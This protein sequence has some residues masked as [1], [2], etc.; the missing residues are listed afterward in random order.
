MYQYGCPRHGYADWVIET[1]HHSVAKFATKHAYITSPHLCGTRQG[2]SFTY[3]SSNVVASF[4]SQAFFPYLNLDHQPLVQGYAYAFHSRDK[5]CLAK[6]LILIIQLYCDDDTQYTAALLLHQFIT[7]VQQSLDRVGDFSL[8][9]KLGR[10]HKKCAVDI[11]NHPPEYAT[12]SFDSIAQ[13][14]DHAAPCI[15][16]ITIHTLS[17]THVSDEHTNSIIRS[18]RQKASGTTRENEFH[19]HSAISTKSF[20]GIPPHLT[21]VF[22]RHLS[23]ALL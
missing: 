9:T 12:L 17:L 8:I 6:Y 7:Q 3:P 22:H 1:S 16:A 18:V 5:R 15:F 23:S 10:N 2:S 19:G 13:S 21:G 14:Y 20:F 4:K 11:I